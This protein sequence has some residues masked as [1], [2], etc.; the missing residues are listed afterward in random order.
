MRLLRA[1]FERA[2][3]MVYR[4]RTGEYTIIAGGHEYKA[5]QHY[6]AGVMARNNG[7]AKE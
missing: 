4:A 3:L 2:G 7:P 6:V 5:E 1:A